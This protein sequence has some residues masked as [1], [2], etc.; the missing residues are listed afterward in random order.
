MTA[1]R[2]N[3]SG[4]FAFPPDISWADGIFDDMMVSRAAI[5]RQDDVLDGYGA[6]STSTYV[7]LVRDVPCLVR[8]LKGEELNT[9]PAPASQTSHGIQEFL[10]FMRVL[11]VDT[12]AVPLSI[13]H[14]MQILSQDQV[15]N[16]DDYKDLNDPNAGAV[17]Y[18]ITNVS[19]PVLMDHHLEVSATVITP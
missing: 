8:N 6:S 9:P 18:N 16:G 11:T 10:I 14:W 2:T 5:Y 13:K 3:T 1:P 12:P 17:K 19:N 4:L 15:L 7:E